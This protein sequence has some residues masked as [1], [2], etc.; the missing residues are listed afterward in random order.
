M[1]LNCEIKSKKEQ[2]DKSE[3]ME[4]VFRFAQRINN[5]TALLWIFLIR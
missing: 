4:I 3:R 2:V 5:K 1:Y